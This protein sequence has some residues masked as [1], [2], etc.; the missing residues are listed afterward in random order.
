VK[1]EGGK[2]EGGE[3]GGGGE[4]REKKYESFNPSFA[5]C[6]EVKYMLHSEMEIE[7]HDQ[8]R[9]IRFYPP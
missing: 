5:H 2:G 9:L 1:E 8:L 3:G 7:C 6:L 4:K